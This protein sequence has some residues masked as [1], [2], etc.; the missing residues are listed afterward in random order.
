MKQTFSWLLAILLC[1]TTA[2]QDK[3]QFRALLVTKTAG[4]HHESINE[5][6]AAIKKLAERNFFDVQWHQ[7]A[8]PVTDKYL[9]NFQVLIFLNTTGDIFK[10]AEQ[11]VIEK[12]IRAGKGFV[13][14]HAASDTE[15]GWDWY[16][17]MVGRMF[18][19]HPAVQTARLKLTANG[20]PGLQGF[21]GDQL[22]TD[23]WYEFGPEK[24]NDLT[25]VLAVDES[26]YDVK[27]QWGEKKG[28]GMG[29]LHPVAWYHNYDGGR[30]FYT[31]LGHLPSIYSEQA[32][33]NHVYAGI[34]W[35]ATGKK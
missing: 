10:D 2:A 35:A 31:A 3:K 9:E 1:C 23:E 17:K 6:V 27:V 5:G 34:F 21:T 22:W 24:S 15:Y 33:L 12:F 7:D 29:A 19:I 4:W 32:F 18:H 13:G 25:Y 14:I 11:Q 26:S 8:I 16:T 28:Q 30:A 20:F